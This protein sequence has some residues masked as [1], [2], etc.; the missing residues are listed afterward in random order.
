MSTS[1][2]HIFKCDRCKTCIPR[3]EYL[4]CSQCKLNL[5]LG[6]A[7]VPFVRFNIME[8]Q[9][10]KKWK[11]DKCLVKNKSPLPA[12]TLPARNS[13]NGTNRDL[14]DATYE[15]VNTRQR[16]NPRASSVELL[17]N[18]SDNTDTDSILCEKSCLSLPDI[19]NTGTKELHDEIIL[20][21][22]KLASAHVEI[23]KLNME[24]TDLKK[25]LDDQ[26]RKGQVLKQLL[27][28]PTPRKLTPIKTNRHKGTC[29]SSRKSSL[30]I[31]AGDK[32][33]RIERK[34]EETQVTLA[35]PSTTY[36]KQT[37]DFTG[38]TPPKIYIVGGQQCVGLGPRLVHSR[39]ESKY[40]RYS[41]SA[42]TKP[43]APAEEI[44]KECDNVEDSSRNYLL[45][46]AGEDDTNPMKVVIEFASK[47][48]RFNF[49][50]I[51]VLAINDNTSLNTYKLNELISNLCRNIPNC[52]F[53]NIHNGR[54]QHTSNAYLNM[55]CKQI[56]FII[57]YRYYCDKYLSCKGLHEILKNNRQKT[58]TAKQNVNPKKRGTIPYYFPVLDKKIDNI[59]TSTPTRK[60]LD[61]LMA[62]SRSPT[63]L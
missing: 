6:C 3:R 60:N 62:T 19:N 55:T 5:D 30:P 31:A 36:E 2:S 1:K 44:L 50:N 17:D 4:T 27:T 43:N 33:Q 29:L 23:D 42:V 35:P 7:N 22:T 39:L 51:I 9:R 48:K 18:S 57:D 49:I 12:Q 45:L 15:N 41:I 25:K 24:V 13:S 59:V 56:N 47:L 8:A 32:I 63:T 46:C 26:Q 52:Q 10:K 20:L 54:L 34:M 53:V 21:K 16:K 38:D 11:C 40:G 28:E 58:N 14:S 37:P 61:F